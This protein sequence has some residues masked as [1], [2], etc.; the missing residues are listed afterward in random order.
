MTS[1]S[2]PETESAPVASRRRLWP[3]LAGGAVVLA[4]A[5]VAVLALAGRSF[6]A[7][8]TLSVF[9]PTLPEQA[10]QGGRSFQDIKQ[11][12][13]VVVYDGAGKTIALGTLDAGRGTTSVECRF[14]FTVEGVP[15]G[16]DIY[17]VEISNRGVVKLNE[18]QMRKPIAI[19]LGQ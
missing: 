19:T 10:C 16:Q 11:G 3:W 1:P 18:D 4:V 17:G 14:T 12:A 6:D 9:A 8:G 7:T 13:P 15:S 5:V 2:F